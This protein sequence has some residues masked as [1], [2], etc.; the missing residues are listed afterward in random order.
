MKA[1]VIKLIS[2]AETTSKEKRKPL[3][4]KKGTDVMFGCCNR[5]VVSNPDLSVLALFAS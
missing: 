1:I 2:Y 5:A 3:A 4:A